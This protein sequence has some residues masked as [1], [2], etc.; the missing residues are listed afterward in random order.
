MTK[1]IVRSWKSHVVALLCGVLFAGGA[2]AAEGGAVQQAGNDLGDRASLQR[3]AQLRVPG[4]A[5]I[6]QMG[7]AQAEADQED[8]HADH[9]EQGGLIHRGQP[10]GGGPAQ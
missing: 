10:E 2:L 5:E 6:A 4:K 9:P 7:H 8:L 3:G 1:P